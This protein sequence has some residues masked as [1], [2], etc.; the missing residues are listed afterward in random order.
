MGSSSVYDETNVSLGLLASSY[1]SNLQPRSS[2]WP[3]KLDVTVGG[4]IG[5]GDTALSTIVR[6]C[7]EEAL[8]DAAYVRENVRPVG[9]LP[10]PNRS[11]AGWILPG[12]YYLYDLRLEPDGSIVP[13]TNTLDGEVESFELMDAGTVLQNLVE[14]RFKA[15][16]ALAMVDFFI[17]HGF[18]TEASDSKYVDVCRILKRDIGL[19][20]P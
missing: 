7:S 8:L 14:G 4:G 17:R 6:E 13:R 12:L 19:P 3:G 11:P 18:I 16:S 2:R 9:I 15:S 5:L 1:I 10:F 20:V